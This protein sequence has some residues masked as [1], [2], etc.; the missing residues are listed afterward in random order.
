MAADPKKPKNVEN[1]D[2]KQ[3]LQQGG[4]QGGSA[5]AGDLSDLIARLD[6]A[7]GVP[8]SLRIAASGVVETFDL[9]KA[10]A[11]VTVAFPPCSGEML[12]LI[13]TKDNLNKPLTYGQKD[14]IV[15]YF[16]EYFRFGA[17]HVIIR[18]NLFEHIDSDL[19]NC[20]TNPLKFSTGGLDEHTEWLGDCCICSPCLTLDGNRNPVEPYLD[21]DEREPPTEIRRLFIGDVVWLSFMERMGIPQILGAI[22]DAY[23]CNGRLPISNGSL[24]AGIKDDITALVLETM[25]RQVKTGMSSTVRDRACL[26][27]T[28]LGWT[29][30]AGRKLKLDT[31]VNTGLNTLFHKLIYHS[32]EFY[33]DKRL[34]VAIRGTAAP[35]APP[36]VATLITIRDTIDLLKKRFETFDYGR[37]Y[38]NTLS[39]IIWTIAG[40]SV[41]RALATTIGIP[42][43]FG[44]PDEF[45][46][47]A[48]DILVLKR[49]ITSGDTNRYLVHKECADKGRDILLD[50]E[51]VNHKDVT[52][53]TG[54][55]EEWLTQVE[56]KIEGYRTAYRNLTG[57]D[58]GVSANPVIEQQV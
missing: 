30:D 14:D 15:R 54:D 3:S 10:K 57:V 11:P 29:S 33:K 24:D 13:L 28:T 27:R 37:N 22:L 2:A 4:A 58:L 55:L 19:L 32:L 7:G 25:T 46:P 53:V 36:S 5:S 21:D 50:L 26:Y 41:I 40:M 20:G 34:A 9:L 17:P 18:G 1:Y 35:V 42:P 8:I 12:A 56:A 6:K 51:V 38:Y 43:A 47:A 31:N 44:S 23:A 45:I 48:Y 52:P 39:G 16:E 49:P